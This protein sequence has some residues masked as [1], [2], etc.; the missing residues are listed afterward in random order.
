MF[1]LRV[2]A[3]NCTARRK[4]KVKALVIVLRKKKPGHVLS[5]RCLI[6]TQFR[7]AEHVKPLQRLSLKQRYD[8]IEY[9]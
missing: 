7:N 6:H 4:L 1:A 9:Y 5:A 2:T 8:S 3:L